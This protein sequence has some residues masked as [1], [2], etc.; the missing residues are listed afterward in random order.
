MNLFTK[1]STRGAN[2]ST[3][4]RQYMTEM[5][6]TRTV[7]VDRKCIWEFLYGQVSPLC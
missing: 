1:K 4:K 2:G 7:K 6:E 5:K 3:C